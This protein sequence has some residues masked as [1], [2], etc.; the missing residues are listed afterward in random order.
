MTTDAAP[1]VA[2]LEP[3]MQFERA[4]ATPIA[5]PLP[6]DLRKVSE[7]LGTATDLVCR[8][9]MARSGAEPWPLHRLAACIESIQQ[10]RKDLIIST[11]A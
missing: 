5:E 2:V 3:G 11:R 6:D 4:D 9:I 1:T 10:A 7:L 8:A